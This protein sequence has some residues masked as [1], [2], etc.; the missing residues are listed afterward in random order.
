VW[1]RQAR[2]A[3]IDG[4]NELGQILEADVATTLRQVANYEGI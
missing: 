4:G 1:I 3:W 2:T